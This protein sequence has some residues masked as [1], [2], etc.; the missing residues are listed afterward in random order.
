MST[1]NDISPEMFKQA[2]FNALEQVGEHGNMEKT[3]FAASQ[4]TRRK[5]REDRFCPAILPFEDVS[6]SDLDRFL[7][8]ER[9]AIICE[10]EPD[11]PGAIGIPFEGTGDS[12]GYYGDKYLLQFFSNTTPEWTKNID[13]LRTYRMDLRELICDNSLRDLSRKCDVKFME[14]VDKVCGLLPAGINEDGLEQNVWYPGG[15][16]RDNWVN[17]TLLLGD[18]DL[19]NGCFLCNRRTFAEFQRWTRNEAGGD[20]SQDLFLKGNRAFES[21]KVGNIDFIVTM[22]SDLVPNGV[23]Y[24]FTKPNY[25]GRAASLQKPTMYIK[26]DK[27]IIRFSCREKIGMTIAN[28]AGVQKVTFSDLVTLRGGDGRME[29]ADFGQDGLPTTKVYTRSARS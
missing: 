5:L 15:L 2:F 4:M 22:K 3:A 12:F 1:E 17:S 13:R 25:L 19:L 24:E 28:K 9:L 14:I 27:D 23:I 7:K 18:R 29:S 21:A 10:M 20:V 26:K 11:S 8:S 16:T 6:N